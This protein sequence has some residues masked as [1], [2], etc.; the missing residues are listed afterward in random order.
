MLAAEY[1]V[2]ALA[3]ILVTPGTVPN[4]QRCV[5]CMQYERFNL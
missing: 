2:V 1:R 5:A 4:P 3:M